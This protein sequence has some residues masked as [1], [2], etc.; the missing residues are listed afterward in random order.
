MQGTTS[1]TVS[2][3]SG[4]RDI[5]GQAGTG[6]NERITDRWVGCLHQ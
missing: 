3:G 2:R 4:E 1:A 6:A 5:A